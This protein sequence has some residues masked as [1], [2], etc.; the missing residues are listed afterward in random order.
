MEFEYLSLMD[1]K[2]AREVQDSVALDAQRS[3]V[4]ADDLRSS[5]TVVVIRTK[6]LKT[7]KN[8]SNH[9]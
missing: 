4:G 5:F 6:R 2:S 8:Q 3:A 1:V 9:W 7:T